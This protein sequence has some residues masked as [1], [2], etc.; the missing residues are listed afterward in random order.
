M[1]GPTMSRLLTTL[2]SEDL[3]NDGTSDL[4]L[5]NN[6]S[7]FLAVGIPGPGTFAEPIRVV[8]NPAFASQVVIAEVTGDSS[9]DIVALGID[10]V[11]IYAGDNL[12][13]FEDRGSVPVGQS[14]LRLAVADVTGDGQADLL[15]ANRGQC[16]SS[17][18]GNL[19][20]LRGDS[21]EFLPPDLA[22]I[23][24]MPLDLHLADLNADGR[25]DAIVA[26][27]SGV[28]V[29]LGTE[30]G[31]NSLVSSASIK[32]IQATAADFN[33]D[34]RGDMV[35]SDSS[36]LFILSGSQGGTFQNQTQIAALSSIRAIESGDLNN[37]GFT[38]LVVAVGNSAT[39]MLGNG[40]GTFREPTSLAAGASVS[41]I[42][43]VDLN[44]DG[45]LDIALT[46]DSADDVVLM[47]NNGDATFA[48]PVPAPTG[49]NPKDIVSG[50]LDG[51]GKIDLVHPVWRL[52]VGH[53]SYGT[54]RWIRRADFPA[55]TGGARGPPDRRLQC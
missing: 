28:M 10:S 50:D 8:P 27:E 43:L 4:V 40:D 13:G 2:R 37:D 42:N 39:I 23:E 53:D 3:T 7:V 5:V 26:D 22:A 15:T 55:A 35:V 41:S 9:P 33:G 31:L 49:D 1:S 45:F 25:A 36:G 51:D 34:G 21:G 12:G 24:T 11:R 20:F 47:I 16:C 46:R 48:N 18:V 29:I 52:L 17:E 19:T 54:I 44:Q 32:V 38:D 14:P 30:S 6:N